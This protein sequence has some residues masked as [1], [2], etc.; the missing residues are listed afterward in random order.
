MLIAE[1]II[2]GLFA[3]GLGIIVA[4]IIC[5]PINILVEKFADIS[6]IAILHIGESISLILLSIGL[7][8]IAGIIPA[9]MATKKDPVVDLRS[10]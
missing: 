7:N 6:N 1:T 8:V 2:E 10:E 4:F 9:K 5:Q 3:G